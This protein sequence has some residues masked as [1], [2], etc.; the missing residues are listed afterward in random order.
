M[1]EGIKIQ[2]KAAVE[3]IG[4]IESN[5]SFSFIPHEIKHFPKIKIKSSCLWN[6]PLGT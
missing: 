5:L 2:L 4:I 3:N 1:I 6:V